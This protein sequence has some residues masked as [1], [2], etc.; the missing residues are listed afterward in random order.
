MFYSFFP[1]EVFY[2]HLKCIFLLYFSLDQP[3]F[4]GSTATLASGFHTSHGRT[5]FSFRG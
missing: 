1:Q 3:S 2:I 4:K 5:R